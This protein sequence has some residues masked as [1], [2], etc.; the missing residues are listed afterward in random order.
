MIETDAAAN[1][2]PAKNK[3]IDRI[4]GIVAAIMACGAAVVHEEQKPSVD[5][6][7]ANLRAGMEA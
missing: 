7:L 3:S 6:W 2:K 1:R 4:D 5:Q